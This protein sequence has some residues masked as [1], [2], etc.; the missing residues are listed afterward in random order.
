MADSQLILELMFLHIRGGKFCST[1][2]LLTTKSFSKLKKKT[3]KLFCARIY[4]RT[5]LVF[6]SLFI[7]FVIR[8]FDILNGYRDQIIIINARSRKES[9]R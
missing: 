6:I 7:V 5:V 4:G 8:T 3:F 2:R 9:Q 1:N